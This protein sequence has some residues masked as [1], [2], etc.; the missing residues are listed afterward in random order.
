VCDPRPWK[1][2]AVEIVEMGAH[3]YQ[4]PCQIHTHTDRQTD[5]QTDRYEFNEKGVA[6]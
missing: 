3:T 6:E 2:F 4:T 1:N 5:R